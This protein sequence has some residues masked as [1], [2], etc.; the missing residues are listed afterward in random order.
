MRGPGWKRLF[1]SAALAETALAT[2]AKGTQI[3]NFSLPR[4][5]H[6]TKKTENP[7]GKGGDGV[8]VVSIR[9]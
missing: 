6:M 2:F 5:T 7:A 4:T 3:K 9:L 8:E 1:R